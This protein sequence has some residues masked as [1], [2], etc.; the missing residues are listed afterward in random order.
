MF[1]GVFDQRR[2]TFLIEFFA[3]TRG[4]QLDC[5][6]G[7]KHFFCDFFVGEAGGNEA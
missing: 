5:R 2:A 4:V 1:A 6:F 7:Q 3:D